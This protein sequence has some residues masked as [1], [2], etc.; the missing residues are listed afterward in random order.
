MA[1]HQC[2]SAEL[3]CPQ[4]ELVFASVQGGY[5]LR[6]AQRGWEV[7]AGGIPAAGGFPFPA[8]LKEQCFL[9]LIQCFLKLCPELGRKRIDVRVRPEAEEGAA[10]QGLSGE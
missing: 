1:F 10:T 4:T 9:K 6:A 8:A 5:G 7:P 3:C 2:S